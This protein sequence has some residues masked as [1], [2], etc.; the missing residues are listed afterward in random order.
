[1]PPLYN[2][3][4]NIP[5]PH[6]GSKVIGEMASALSIDH[7]WP[8]MDLEQARDALLGESNFTA[9]SFSNTDGPFST[10]SR[11]HVKHSWDIYSN[12]KDQRGVQT[13]ISAIF[14]I[15]QPSCYEELLQHGPKTVCL[16]DKIGAKDS[17]WGVVSR[18][19]MSQ[20]KADTIL[21]DVLRSRMREAYAV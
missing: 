18:E 3:F 9:V 10:P 11:R 20:L 5:H 19:V 15:P 7:Q 12:I 14:A 17:S 6:F 4:I 2:S 16:F 13:A 21:A 1:L 8:S